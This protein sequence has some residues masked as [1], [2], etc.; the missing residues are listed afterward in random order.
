MGRE[1]LGSHP[2]VR[3]WRSL[4]P[5]APDPEAIEV[6][7]R[8]RRGSVCRLVGVGPEGSSVV[9][10]QREWEPDDPEVVM[11]VRI[12]PLLDV[13]TLECYGF[14]EPAGEG[15]ATLFLED[16]GEGRF[17]RSSAA[18][19]ALAGRWLAALHAAVEETPEVQPL[20][21]LLPDRGPDHFGRLLDRAQG[22]IGRWRSDAA[23]AE[24]AR[25]TLLATLE[26]V[27]SVWADVEETCALLPRTVVHGDFREKNVRLK[28]E[29][30][31]TISFLLLDWEYAGVGC[32]AVDL[33]ANVL[34][35]YFREAALPVPRDDLRR[36][37]G[38]F[39]TVSAVSWFVEAH[40]DDWWERVET[41]EIYTSMLEKVLRIGA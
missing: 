6:L 38:L 4:R 25:E 15:Q 17:S 29:R 12:H 41:M 21:A 2:V 35:A 34:D 22:V 30:D 13:R 19:C 37:G 31:G 39:S 26:E 8:D 11:H 14:V 9:A 7:A 24:A 16:A 28:Q 5:R 27:D 33:D 18:H 32:P 1:D 40:W 20:L 23:A 3:A 36:A 10:K